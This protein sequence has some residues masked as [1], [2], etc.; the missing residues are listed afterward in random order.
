[1]EQDAGAKKPIVAKEKLGKFGKTKFCLFLLPILK[2][3]LSIRMEYGLNINKID[4][5]GKPNRSI[6]P[7]HSRYAR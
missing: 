3:E 7:N 4:M 2:H 5:D 1:M 6:W